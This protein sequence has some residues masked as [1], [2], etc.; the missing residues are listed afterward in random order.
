MSKTRILA[1]VAFNAVQG[2]AEA[3]GGVGYG[4]CFEWQ[5]GNAFNYSKA[6]RGAP[7]DPSGMIADALDIS[8]MAAMWYL[9]AAGLLDEESSNYGPRRI[10]KRLGI[11]FGPNDPWPRFPFAEW[12]AELNIIRGK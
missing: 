2:A 8:P 10:I 5:D 11:P 9:S 12:V 3:H 1:A 4:T 6:A 7:L